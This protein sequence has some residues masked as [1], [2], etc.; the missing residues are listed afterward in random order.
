MTENRMTN[1]ADNVIITRG[2]WNKP[3]PSIDLDN[4]PF[5]DGL[6]EHK[7]LL[8]CCEECG[9]SYWPKTY[10]QNHPNQPF[11]ENMSWKEANGM[12][13]IFAFNRHHW[14][15]NPNF[16][17]PYVYALIELDEGP[18]VSSTITNPET[19][20][21]VQHVGQRVQVVYEDV[22]DEGFTVPRFRVIDGA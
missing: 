12:G 22:V 21:E 7:F 1:E 3:R 20:G 19:L 15:F 11:A 13:R 16:E 4:K 9:A 18:L 17:V 5:W 8:W 6:R 10:C 2:A 14:A